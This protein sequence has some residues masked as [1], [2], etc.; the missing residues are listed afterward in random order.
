MYESIHFLGC[1]NVHIDATA[2]IQNGQLCHPSETAPVLCFVNF[3]LH[4][5]LL[6][7][8]IVNDFD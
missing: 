3:V 2:A 5:M 8:E 6:E 7:N 4:L 1:S